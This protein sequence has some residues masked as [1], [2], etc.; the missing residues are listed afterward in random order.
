MFHAGD[1]DGR[2][3]GLIAR[4]EGHG[5]QARAADLL[6]AYR[7]TLRTPAAIEAWRRVLAPAPR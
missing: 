1:D 3:A 5:A 2:I 7:G 4:R 6:D